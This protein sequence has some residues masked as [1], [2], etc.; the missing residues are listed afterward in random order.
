MFGFVGSNGGFMLQGEADIVQSVQQ[1]VMSKVVDMEFGGETVIV[2]DRAIFEIDREFVIFDFVRAL[3]DL[4]DLVI[5]EA[6]REQAVLETVI[7]KNV[8][9]RRGN[10]DAESVV[11]ERPDGVL[12]G[13]TTAK[14]LAGDENR[15]LLVPRVV[16]NKVRDMVALGRVAPVVK[17]KLTKAGAFNALEKLLGDNLIGINI[18]AIERSDGSSVFAKGFHKFSSQFVVAVSGVRL[19]RSALICIKPERSHLRVTTID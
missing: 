17:E 1:A 10:D 6:N 3:H 15:G 11:C 14:I 5:T 2:G 13:R 8:A 19:T 16:K 4:R 9:E 18:D 12:T 7:S